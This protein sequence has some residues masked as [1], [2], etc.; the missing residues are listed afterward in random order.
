MVRSLAQCIN[1]STIQKKFA[2]N[3]GFKTITF[4][5]HYVQSWIKK[6]RWENKL[7]G[8]VQRFTRGYSVILNY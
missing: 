8:T 6:L 5:F 4:Q 1:R 7:D 3:D 2:I